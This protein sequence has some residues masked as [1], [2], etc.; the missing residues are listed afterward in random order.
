MPRAQAL[1]SIMLEGT[2]DMIIEPHAVP[3]GITAPVES[4]WK[5]SRD[6]LR[7]HIWA[8]TGCDFLEVARFLVW[9]KN[10][11][12]GKFMLV[13]TLVATSCGMLGIVYRYRMRKYMP[14]R[15]AARDY[16]V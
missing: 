10:T 13:L 15:I 16:M 12:N 2:S 9:L 8:M 14:Y 11:F 3:N 7:A 4:A 6:S 5:T 1:A